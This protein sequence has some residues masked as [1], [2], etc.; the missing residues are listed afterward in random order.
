MTGRRA[1]TLEI[2]NKRLR[3]ELRMYDTELEILRNRF[4]ELKDENRCLRAAV[5]I[6]NSVGKMTEEKLRIV[7]MALGQ[8]KRPAQKGAGDVADR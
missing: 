1:S 3:G 5:H 4:H 7:E 8:E 6:L 2:E